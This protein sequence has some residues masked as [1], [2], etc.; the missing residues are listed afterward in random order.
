MMMHQS[1]DSP[2][3][4]NSMQRPNYRVWGVYAD[5]ASH[6]T[7][8]TRIGVRAR[9]GPEVFPMTEQRERF[10]V[11]IAPSHGIIE[12]VRVRFP[13]AVFATLPTSDFDVLFHT[14]AR[15][16]RYRVTARNRET[17]LHVC[18]EPLA[19]SRP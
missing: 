4:Q 8:V 19:R 2:R 12:A 17:P 11:G 14:S 7:S 9:S 16:E 6:T 3:V 1:L 13:E 5:D 18:N 10:T 15:V